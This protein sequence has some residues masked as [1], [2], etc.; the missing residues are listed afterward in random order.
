MGITE[1]TGPIIIEL[2]GI[3]YLYAFNKEFDWCDNDFDEELSCT[4]SWFPLNVVTRQ[5]FKQDILP[6][7]KQKK[8]MITDELF[9]KIR[10]FKQNP[11]NEN[12]VPLTKLPVLK[13]GMK[14]EK[15]QYTAVNLMLAYNK[16]GFFMGQGSGK[17]LIAITWLMNVKPES[18]LIVTPQKVIGQY[19]KEL[20]FQMPGN[21]Y[22]ITNYE[23]L[24]HYTKKKYE[25]LILDESHKCKSFTSSNNKNCRIIA[26]NCKYIYLFTGTPQD[27]SR[28]EI[29][30]QLAILDK[31]VMPVKTKIY[32]RYFHINDY[33]QPSS[34]IKDRKKELTEIINSYTWGIKTEDIKE[35]Q[36]LQPA[37]DIIIKCPHPKKF[38]DEMF[39][40]RLLEKGE[41]V[42]M[43]DNPATQR[44]ALRGI[45]SGYLK[46]TYPVE[47]E[48]KKPRVE[49]ENFRSGKE[50][51][52]YKL[53]STI[54]E[55]VIFYEF[56][57]SLKEIEEVLKDSGRTYLI[58]NGTTSK[59]RST[60]RIES[61]KRAEVNYLVIQ[62]RSGNAGLDLY[63]VNHTI[64]YALPESFIVYDQARSRT[65]RWGQTKDCY[66]YHLICEN[67]VEEAIY[68]SLKK[69]KNFTNKL[70]SQYVR[71]E[72]IN[73]GTTNK[74]TNS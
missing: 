69:K 21:N 32:E 46:W 9:N 49:L 41:A 25:A 19:R 50:N 43:G 56:T 3:I 18:C 4:V 6:W 73:Y 71:K 68:N 67:T 65:N 29:L 39:N 17:T 15:H 51:E 52:L 47:E 28:H 35:I 70:Y 20:D 27:K 12:S 30:S 48:G 72:M 42:C 62:S 64:F 2:N 37:H 66:Y 23:Q 36:I 54:P 61:F 1:V 53:T 5:Y 13:E 24:Q 8:C 45:C 58:V 44:L 7:I 60:E 55:G 74:T 16:Y 26:K 31:K 14:F 22:E 33:F 10:Y 63:R 40:D 11:M 34:E 57:E 38:Y 59:K